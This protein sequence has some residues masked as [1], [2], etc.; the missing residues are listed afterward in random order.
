MR[1]SVTSL[2]P[3][4]TAV[5]YSLTQSG[6]PGCHAESTLLLVL[7]PTLPVIWDYSLPWALVS[8]AAGKEGQLTDFQSLFY[9]ATSLFPK[10]WVVV[11][12]NRNPVK[13]LTK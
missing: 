12:E 2:G 1:R 6:S 4:V 9:N 5:S 3:F 10:R 13:Y 8:P 7:P 11:F